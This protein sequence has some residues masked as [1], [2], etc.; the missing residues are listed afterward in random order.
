MKGDI[1]LFDLSSL[2]SEA[3][4]LGINVGASPFAN[5]ATAAGLLGPGAHRED[6]ALSYLQMPK[7]MTTFE[8]PVLPEVEELAAHPQA[9]RLLDQLQ[10]V[11][12]AFASGEQALNS[13]QVVPLAGIDADACALLYQTLGEGEVALMVQAPDYHL[14]VQE[15]VLAGVWWIQQVNADQQLQQ[16]WL[17][18]G[19]IPTAVSRH[20]FPALHSD[21]FELGPRPADLLNGASVMVEL[22][23][24]ARC[25]AAAPLSEPYVVNLSLL[26]FS[27][28]DHRWLNQR[29]RVGHVV[30]L[31]RGYG[32]CRITSTGVA[33]IWRVQYFNST[34]QL[35]LDTLEVVKVPQVACAAREDLEDSAERLREIHAALQA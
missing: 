18:V 8:I 28:E 26:P 34:D 5:P 6:E 29:L 20:A 16:Q 12:D 14:R 25:H 2:N 15:T 23:D 13:S 33:G 19:A 30:I 11:L 22:L 27:D 9:G 24:Q 7:E 31:S 21:S 4:A 17:E 1:P 32:N 3:V 35:I 10:T